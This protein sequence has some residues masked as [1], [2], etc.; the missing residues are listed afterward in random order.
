MTHEP[1]IDDA[2]IIG[3]EHHF[4]P[5]QSET[6]LYLKR[7]L[8]A[9]GAHLTQHKHTH[10]HCS[11]LAAGSVMVSVDGKRWE[12]L[13]APKSLVLK[14]GEAHEVKALSDAVWYCIHATSENDPALI[15]HT[16]IDHDA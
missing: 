6:D 10:D 11:V 7:T 4:L 12:V 1:R 14:A 3:I 5:R 16:L 15:D 9:A 2:A 13:H 8:I